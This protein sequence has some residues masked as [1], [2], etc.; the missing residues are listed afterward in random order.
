MIDYLV[1]LHRNYMTYRR[2]RNQT[3]T[4]MIHL[5]AI[6]SFQ[7]GSESQCQ[8][9]RVCKMCPCKFCHGTCSVHFPVCYLSGLWQRPRP[10]TPEQSR[11]G[12]ADAGLQATRL[13]GQ[14]HITFLDSHLASAYH[15][16]SLYGSN[17]SLT[18]LII[19]LQS[20]STS[21]KSCKQVFEIDSC[22]L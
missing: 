7:Q 13:R 4:F 3:K 11:E 10:Y 12:K 14:S 5:P 1:F 6:F 8:G 2:Y 21:R 20:S 18:F 22:L 19:N 15:S 17:T 9:E 16:N